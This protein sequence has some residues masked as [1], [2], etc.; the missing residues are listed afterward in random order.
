MINSPIEVVKESSTIID[1]IASNKDGNIKDTITIPTSPSD[2]F[3]VGCLCKL[4]NRKYLPR[5]IKCRDYSNYSEDIL[6]QRF[7][8]VDWSIIEDYENV[9][10]CAK[11]LNDVLLKKHF[12]D[13]V[14]VI[15]KRVERR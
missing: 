11:L 10:N 2:H 14:P 5:N 6:I 1:T 12:N 4:N 8:A 3:M 9:K 7:T 15:N 13:I